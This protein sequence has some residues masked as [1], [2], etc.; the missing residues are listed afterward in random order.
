MINQIMKVVCDGA[1][2]MVLAVGG[3]IVLAWIIGLVRRKLFMK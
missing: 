2:Y 3:I 1:V